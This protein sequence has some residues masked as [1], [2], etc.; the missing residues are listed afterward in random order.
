MK[1]DIDRILDAA[2]KKM[3]VNAERIAQAL[4]RIRNILLLLIIVIASIYLVKNE[5]TRTYGIIVFVLAFAWLY[6]Y[7]VRRRGT[8]KR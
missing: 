4:R 8:R 6:S 3:Q 5:T 2:T 7:V 1:I